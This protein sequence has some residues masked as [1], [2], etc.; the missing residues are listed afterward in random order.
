MPAGGGAQHQAAAGA[1][2]HLVVV[3][4][5]GWLLV[6]GGVGLAQ[7]PGAVVQKLQHRGVQQ[8]GRPRPARFGNGIVALVAVGG[9]LQHHRHEVAL[10]VHRHRAKRAAV[11]LARGR[12]FVQGAFGGLAHQFVP[13]LLLVAV[14]VVGVQVVHHVAGPGVGL[15]GG[16]AGLD[17]SKVEGPV[18]GALGLEYNALR[19]VGLAGRG[20]AEQKNLRPQVAVQQVKNAFGKQLGRNP[21]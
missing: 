18:A 13:A 15:Q 6:V 2:Q 12:Q 14:V 3:A 19:L 9:H 16:G 1:A 17:V 4:V 5:E 10:Q 8:V 11:F 20:Q 21:E 7:G